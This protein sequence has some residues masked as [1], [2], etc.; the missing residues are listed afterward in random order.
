MQQWRFSRVVLSLFAVLVLAVAFT[1]LGCPD[2]GG[3]G[4]GPQD[5]RPQDLAGQTFRFP[6]ANVIDDDLEG[7]QAVLAFGDTANADGS[8]PF[9]L[10]F[11]NANA[12]TN[13]NAVIASVDFTITDEIPITVNDHTFAA[14]DQFALDF[15]IETD[16][17]GTRHYVVTN[18]VSGRVVN[19]TFKPGDTGSTGTTGS[20]GL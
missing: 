16:T 11:P 12:V 8:L 13:G 20:S 4:G 15:T 1:M 9:T 2:D 7:Q 5:V 10:D 3:G 6:N 17:D 14:G 19:F 18:P